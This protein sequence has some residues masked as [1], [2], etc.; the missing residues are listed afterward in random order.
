[1][2]VLIAEDDPAQ[3]RLLSHLLRQWGYEPQPVL[4]GLEAIELL[5]SKD[6][7]IALVDWDLPGASGLEICQRVRQSGHYLHAIVL[8]ARTDSEDLTIALEAGASDYLA[9]P[10][11]RNELRAR[12]LV[13]RRMVHLH[14]SVAQMQKLESIGQLAAGVAHEINT[15]AQFVSDNLRFAADSVADLGGAVE[16][17]RAALR[18]LEEA[19]TAP[20]LVERGLA[21]AQRP[22]GFGN[23]EEVADPSHFNY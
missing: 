18:A 5:S 6:L 23:H 13:A 22:N 14:A 21:P 20:E 7:S 12:L 2:K 3:Q 9:K 19:G 16:S 15:P 4:N 8:T 11:S 1:M 17:L 10:F